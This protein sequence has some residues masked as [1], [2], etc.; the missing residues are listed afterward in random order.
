MTEGGE[1]LMT[2]TVYYKENGVEKA[3]IISAKNSYVAKAYI[4]NKYGKVSRVVKQKSQS[5][6]LWQ[7]KIMFW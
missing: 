2:Y 4:A 1:R 7:K 5:I 6:I 3:Q